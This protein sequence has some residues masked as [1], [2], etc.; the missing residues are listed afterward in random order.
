MPEVASGASISVSAGGDNGDA[1]VATS[2]SE[3]R[4]RPWPACRPATASTA[5]PSTI[6]TDTSLGHLGHLGHFRIARSACPL[7][8][9][10]SCT[11][12]AKSYKVAAL[13]TMN[14]MREIARLSD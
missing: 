6:P 1:V 4:T 13:D 8:S 2:T 7:I 14:K 9:E 5:G 11:T 12:R 10:D 3:V